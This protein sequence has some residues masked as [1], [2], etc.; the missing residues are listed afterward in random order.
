MISFD[1]SCDT[2]ENNFSLTLLFTEED[3]QQTYL[4][5]NKTRVTIFFAE[6]CISFP[7]MRNK[8][9]SVRKDK[10]KKTIFELRNY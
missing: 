3:N 9:T 7:K 8:Y 2:T 5:P 10:K 1:L 4:L 6:K